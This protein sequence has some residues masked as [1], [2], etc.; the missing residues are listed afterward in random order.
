MNIVH[1]SIRYSP[2][3][4]RITLSARR[5]QGLMIEVADEGPG[6]SPEHRERIFERFYRID[7]ARSR[8]SPRH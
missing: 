4:T 5:D 2:V 3:E 1:N 7:K 8:R 6:I